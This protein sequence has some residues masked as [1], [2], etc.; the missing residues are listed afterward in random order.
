MLEEQTENQSMTKRPDQ[1]DNE[2]DDHPVVV[3]V[4]SIE[5]S[6]EPEVVEEERKGGEAPVEAAVHQEDA[7]ASAVVDEEIKQIANAENLLCKCLIMNSKSK[8]SNTLA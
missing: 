7:T 5:V 1:S 8:F 6:L 4:G 2:S 3:D